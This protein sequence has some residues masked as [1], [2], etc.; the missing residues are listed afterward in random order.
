[1]NLNRREF[2]SSVAV[3]AGAISIPRQLIAQGAASDNRGHSTFLNPIL[4]GDYPDPTVVRVG[5]IYYMTHSA[6]TYCPAFLIWKSPNLVDWEPVGCAL[7]D[8]DGDLWAPDLTFYN[9]RFYLYYI[10]T[11]GNRVLVADKIEG[12]WSKPIDL[13][14]PH[15]DPGHIATPDGKRYLHLSGGHVVELAADG[16]ST[17]GSVQKVFDAW[18][19]PEDW[20]I[21]C[22]CL[23]SPK[24]FYRDGWYHMIVAQGGTAG[25]AT[26]HMAIHSRSRTPVGPWEYSPFNPIIHTGSREEK[27]WSRGHATALEATDGSWWLVYH[28]YE[29]A[30]YTLGRHTILEPLEW[31]G[32]GWLRVSPG[33]DPAKPLKRPPG[34]IR[35]VQLTHSDN[36]PGTTLNPLWRFWKESGQG[37]HAVSDHT[38]HLKARGS[39]PADGR[40]LTRITGDKAY[41]IE[42]DVAVDDGAEGGLM[43]YYNSECYIGLTLN[44]RG[45]EFHGRGHRSGAGAGSR[46]TGGRGTLRIINRHHDVNLAFRPAGGDWIALGTTYETSGYHHNVFGGFLDLRPA[47]TASGQGEARFRALRYFTLS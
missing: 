1:M 27:W 32:N 3:A 34:G 46:F 31:T 13:K 23:E 33:S 17:V 11:G 16:L 9:G 8:Y 42:V 19:I 40:I 30:Y 21:E 25:P 6:N 43:L 10:T 44:S 18:P 22:V 45:V 37:V 7:K 38:L 5:D 12:P 14:V 28:A 2:I 29:K 35:S 41:R 4:R 36:F 47:L 20:Q 39:S 26:S 15:I 24:L